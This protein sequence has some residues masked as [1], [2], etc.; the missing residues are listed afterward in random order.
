MCV[1][2]DWHLPVVFPF[3]RNEDFV[4]SEM[5]LINWYSQNLCFLAVFIDT[6]TFLPSQSCK[7]PDSVPNLEV[8]RRYHAMD[9]R[10]FH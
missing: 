6:R 10:Y 1:T 2:H 5:V 3:F 4:G 8:L 7:G 9:W